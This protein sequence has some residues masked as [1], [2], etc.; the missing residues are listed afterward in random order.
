M[1]QIKYDI[2]LKIEFKQ[3]RIK[4]YENFD[5]KTRMASFSLQRSK[6]PD[7]KMEKTFYVF[8]SKTQ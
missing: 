4:S 2:M 3:I 6:S 5:F 8:I 7:L 1:K